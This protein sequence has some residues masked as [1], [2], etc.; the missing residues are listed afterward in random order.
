[1]RPLTRDRQFRYSLR[2]VVEEVG[3]AGHDSILGT[4]G[5]E[6]DVRSFWNSILGT[7]G[8][9]VGNSEFLVLNW[10]R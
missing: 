3:N 6:L 7:I 2:V 5:F 10:M 4:I 1:M 8:N 9:E